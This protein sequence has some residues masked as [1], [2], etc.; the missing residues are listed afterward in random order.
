MAVALVAD[1]ERGTA[2]K[3]G[4]ATVEQRLNRAARASRV[5]S[6]ELLGFPFAVQA[7]SIC[8]MDFREFQRQALA[9]L[10]Y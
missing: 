8:S 3:D 1:G 7:W 6:N 4:S 2:S 9:C 5:R 10:L